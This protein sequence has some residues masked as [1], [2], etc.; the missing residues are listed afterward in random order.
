MYGGHWRI[1]LLCI[2]SSSMPIMALKTTIAALNSLNESL[3]FPKASPFNPSNNGKVGKQ[4][5]V[6]ALFLSDF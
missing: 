4:N 5:A 2:R 6:Y 3:N 1:E